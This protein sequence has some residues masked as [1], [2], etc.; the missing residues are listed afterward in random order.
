MRRNLVALASVGW[1]LAAACGP[2][3]AP[4]PDRPGGS[5][6]PG[7]APAGEDPG[8]AEHALTPCL[9][10]CYATCVGNTPEVVACRQDCRD[11]CAGG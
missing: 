4:S 6:D 1:L 8:S 10:Q 9:S 2:A 7:D 5:Q 11:A 3:D